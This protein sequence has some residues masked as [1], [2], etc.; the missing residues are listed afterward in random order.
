MH[1]TDNS[2]T[3]WCE[4][5][6]GWWFESWLLH[7]NDVEPQISPSGV[8]PACEC[9]NE[10][11]QHCTVAVC[12]CAS[13]T[14]WEL[15]FST[16]TP[17]VV[18]KWKRDKNKT[19]NRQSVTSKRS[20]FYSSKR[21]SFEKGE[22]GYFLCTNISHIALSRLIISRK[23]GSRIFGGSQLWHSFEWKSLRNYLRQMEAFISSHCC[24]TPRW[25]CDLCHMP[26]SLLQ[27]PQSLADRVFTFIICVSG[28]SKILARGMC[29]FWKQNYT[30][31]QIIPSLLHTDGW[32]VSSAAATQCW[33]SPAA[34]PWW[35]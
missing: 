8:H 2:I 9:T 21:A 27:G 6:C 4:S 18:L 30:N 23:R 20:I 32:L 33:R 25:A 17:K 15:T 19:K 31:T 5:S 28:F 14:R 29:W 22:C 34:A 12:V 24:R 11:S 26:H 3:Q 35:K 16:K 10:S 7:H 1:I 13:E